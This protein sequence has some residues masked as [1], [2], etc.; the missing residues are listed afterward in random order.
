MDGTYRAIGSRFRTKAQRFG[1]GLS[2]LESLAI[3]VDVAEGI[4]YGCRPMSRNLLCRLLVLL[5]LVPLVAEAAESERAPRTTVLVLRNGG[6]LVGQVVPAGDRYVVLLGDRSEVRV[7]VRDVEMHCIDLDEVYLRKRSSLASNDVAG[8]LNLADWCLQ[9]KLHARV[10][11]QLLTVIALQPRHPRLPGLQRRLHL[12]VASPESHETQDGT[13]SSLI[14]ISDLEKTTRSL[15]PSSVAEFTSQIQPLLLN[16]CGGNS[17]HGSS[18]SS[19]FRLVRPALS[20]SLTRRF[21]LRNLHAVMQWV[22]LED[23]ESSPLLQVPSCAHGGLDTGVFGPREQ[24]QF[25]L[26]AAWVRSATVVPSAPVPDLVS[27]ANAAPATGLLQASYLQP[28]DLPDDSSERSRR[29]SELPPSQESA[30]VQRSGSGE[31]THESPRHIMARDPF[32][33]EV[34]NRRYHRDR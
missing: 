17:C 24:Q 34:F 9:Q 12:A 13:P 22:D 11:D 32:D 3:D 7:P 19:D 26:L 29:L 5:V 18:G 23:P 4:H 1:P 14:P 15:P 33:A 27:E 20:R 25:D 8:H 16:Q 10:A 6:V 28:V 30:S 31:P 2:G 21:T